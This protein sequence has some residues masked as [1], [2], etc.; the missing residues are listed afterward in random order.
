MN[1]KQDIED[2]L[3]IK[4]TVAEKFSPANGLT[5]KQERY[6]K[7]ITGY[8][9]KFSIEK[10]ADFLIMS[11]ADRKTK[12][13]RELKVALKKIGDLKKTAWNK[14]NFSG[15]VKEYMLIKKRK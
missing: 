14:D 3:L 6:Y 12:L 9:K 4:G 11:S 5:E 2:L 1:A 13:G 8:L 15:L 10:T 7:D